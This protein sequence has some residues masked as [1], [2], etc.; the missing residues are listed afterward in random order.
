MPARRPGA[1][2]R[3]PEGGVTSLAQHREATRGEDH[4]NSRPRSSPPAQEDA[5][6]VEFGVAD[7]LPDG[8]GRAGFDSSGRRAKLS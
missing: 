3:S 1:D 4:Q 6:F 2:D 5:E 8:E 7:R